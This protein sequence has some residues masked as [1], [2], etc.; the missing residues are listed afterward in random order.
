MNQGYCKTFEGSGYGSEMGEKIRRDG[1]KVFK[2]LTSK[3]KSL[4]IAAGKAVCKYNK[5]ESSLE[6]RNQSIGLAVQKI[7]ISQSFLQEF[8][9]SQKFVKA[10]AFIGM[11]MQTQGKCIYP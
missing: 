11:K 4:V 9:Q 6:E 5:G 2:S 10:S 8:F 7:G 3:E 1:E